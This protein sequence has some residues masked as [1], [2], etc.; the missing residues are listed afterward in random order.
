M[1]MLIISANN[2]LRVVYCHELHIISKTN[3]IKITLFTC[4]AVARTSNPHKHRNIALCPFGLQIS[5]IPSNRNTQIQVDTNWLAVANKN[6]GLQQLLSD[7]SGRGSCAT[8]M[9]TG[10]LHDHLLL[11]CQLI[12][13]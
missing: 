10:K 9:E 7:W 6:R 8:F 1:Q 2:R 13:G 4:Y 11:S 12:R 5:S 3:R